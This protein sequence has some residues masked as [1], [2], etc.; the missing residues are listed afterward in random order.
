MQERKW[1]EMQQWLQAR[2]DECARE[3]ASLRAQ[4]RQDEAVFQQIRMNVF[5]LTGPVLAVSMK[6]ADPEEA[7]LR[8]MTQIPSTWEAARQK[9]EAHGDSVQVYLEEIKLK[10]AEEIRQTF[11]QMRSEEA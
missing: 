9:A 1:Q 4:G 3:Q 5:G 6:D 10:A 11:M 8:R 7:F 2:K